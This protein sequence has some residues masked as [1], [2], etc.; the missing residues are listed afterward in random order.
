M[1]L[2]IESGYPVL[3]VDLGSGPEKIIHNKFVSDNIW[4]QIIIDRLAL[5][6]S[7]NLNSSNKILY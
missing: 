5:I 3:I 7:I 6:A 1:A 4:R 2:L